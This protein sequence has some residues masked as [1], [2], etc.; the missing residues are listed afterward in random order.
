MMKL[1]IVKSLHFCNQHTV[2]V[3]KNVELY[4]NPANPVVITVYYTKLNWR[5]L[6]YQRCNQTL[7]ILRTDKRQ[8]LHFYLP[9]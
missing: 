4:N 1:S 8:Y 9:R 5:L 3:Y 6:E 7:S 2:Y